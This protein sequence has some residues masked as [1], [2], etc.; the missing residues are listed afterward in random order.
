VSNTTARNR[1]GTTNLIALLIPDIATTYMGEILRGVSHAAERL[2][3]GLMLYTQGTVNHAERT[4]HYLSL[5]SNHLVDGVLMVVPRDYEVIVGDL[6]NHNLAY[7]IIDHHNGTENE[8]SVTATNRKGMRDAMRHLL[9]DFMQ[10]T[11]FQ[12]AQTLL[13]LPHPPTAIVASNDLMAF[14]AMDAAKA[15]GLTI[16]HDISIVGFD[17]IFMSSQ[18]HPTLTTVRQ[19]LHNM[20]EMAL[21]MLVT[22]LQGR[23]VLNPRRELPTELIIRESTGRAT[24]K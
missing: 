9:A 15:A 14:G 19:P 4:S 21:D 17:D 1:S 22:L 20:G 23:T 13:R 10:P 6:K 16:G 2:D 3:F 24:Q 7:V 8:T 11:G 5:L 12:Q 18:V